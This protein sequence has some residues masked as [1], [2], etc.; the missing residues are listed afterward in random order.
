MIIFD[1]SRVNSDWTHPPRRARLNRATQAGS[2]QA[3]HAADERPAEPHIGDKPPACN[4]HDQGSKETSEP[5]RTA[6]ASH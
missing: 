3:T 2:Y 5:C 4:N 1:T 6:Q